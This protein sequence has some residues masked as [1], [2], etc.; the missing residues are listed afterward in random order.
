MDKK[1]Y[2]VFGICYL[3][4]VAACGK[5]EP[6]APAAQASVFRESDFGADDISTREIEIPVIARDPFA[7]P[8]GYAIAATVENHAPAAPRVAE[9]PSEASEPPKAA[10]EWPE[11]KVCGMVRGDDGQ[12]RASIECEGAP[13]VFRAGE[14][15]TSSV[16]V[17]RTDAR[18]V[19]FVHRTGEAKRVNIDE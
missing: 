15:V 8:A 2:L 4:F 6:V 14:R 17:A 19:L 5:T 10:P 9:Q 13:K 3:L 18:G 1:A 7:K 12:W 11:L 16:R